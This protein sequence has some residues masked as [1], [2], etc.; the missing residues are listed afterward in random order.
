M[1]HPSLQLA[2]VSTA[3]DRNSFL[4]FW[5]VDGVLLWFLVPIRLLPIAL[6]MGGKLG[7]GTRLLCS[8][9]SCCDLKSAGGPRWSLPSRQS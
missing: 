5:P 2:P 6:V 7:Q 8:W 3:S 4:E 9:P 1:P